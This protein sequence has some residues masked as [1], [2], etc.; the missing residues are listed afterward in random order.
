MR[1]AKFW[2]NKT[3]NQNIEGF[4]ITRHIVKTTEL[5][6]NPH[7]IIWFR[8]IF[9][10]I[11]TILIPSVCLAYFNI[12]TIIKLKKKKLQSYTT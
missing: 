5:R 11:F 12:R 2:T 3:S 9:Q 10:F 7:Y 8:N 6:M 1:N 4:T